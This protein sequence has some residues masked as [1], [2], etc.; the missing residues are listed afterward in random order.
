MISTGINIISSGDELKKVLVKYV[1]DSL[2]NPHA[3]ILAKVRQLRIVRELDSKQYNFLKRQ[4]PYLVCG[5]FNPSFRRTENFAYTEY[6][7][8]DIDHISEKDLNL[9]DIKKAIIK[10]ERVCLCF[11]S[12]GEDGL[13]VLFKLK[14]RCYDAGLY[15]LFYKSFL[16]SF[17][18]QY[19]LQ[20]VVDV[21]TS[22]V[23]R[24]C[25]VSIDSEAYYN[26]EP[27]LVDINSF[28]SANNTQSAFD[29]K[30]Q[31]EQQE[32]SKDAEVKTEEKVIDPDQATLVKIKQILNNKETKEVE[33]SPVFVP[34]IL[35]K[36]IED[37]KAFIEQTGVVVTEIINIQYGK[38][39]RIKMG[40]KQ[41]EVN[42]FYGKR[43]FS[44]IQSPRTGTNPELNV[45]M[46][47]LIKQYLAEK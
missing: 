11:I 20:Q 23:T 6:F 38:K 27:T 34:E 36:I 37:L 30:H 9:Q 7:I 17:S 8:I 47:D 25:F 41:A 18:T 3:D 4:L 35:N 32:V 19:N 13:K 26:P 14:E 22:D 33:K 21:K 28:I 2:R 43:G 24:A 16:Q 44:V 12:P 5:I 40:L 45:L 29:I 15:S 42:L 39:I 31:L 10:D 46:V 1:Y